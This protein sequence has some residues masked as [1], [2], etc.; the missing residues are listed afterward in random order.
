MVPFSSDHLGY[1]FNVV[2]KLPP[3]YFIGNYKSI[4]CPQ[5]YGGESSFDVGVDDKSLERINKDAG[6]DGDLKISR[7]SFSLG[8]FDQ[9]KEINEKFGV[10]F[11]SHDNSH[12]AEVTVRARVKLGSM[13]LNIK[14]GPSSAQLLEAQTLSNPVYEVKETLPQP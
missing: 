14:E 12:C 13:G 6:L 2:K 3:T 9:Q 1:I 10:V 5:L 7:L 8:R 4:D 11:P